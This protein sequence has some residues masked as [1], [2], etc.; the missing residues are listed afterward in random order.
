[1]STKKYDNRDKIIHVTNF[2]NNFKTLILENILVLDFIFII[3]FIR[4][5]GL[6]L[7]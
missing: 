7:G 5:K 3:V 4:I 1:M 2:M 6:P